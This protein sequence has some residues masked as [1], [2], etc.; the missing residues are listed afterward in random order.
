MSKPKFDLTFYLSLAIISH[1][2][3]HRCRRPLG[4]TSKQLNG[5]EIAAA[6]LG[7]VFLMPKIALDKLLISGK[8]L[9]L[10][11]K[12]VVVDNTEHPNN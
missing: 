7:A 3:S 8:L 1:V 11:S 9:R 2:G 12:G 5:I 10:S 4:G 6:P